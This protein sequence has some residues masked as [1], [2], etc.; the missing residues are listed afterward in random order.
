[1]DLRVGD[2]VK[3]KRSA[4]DML[5]DF[6]QEMARSHNM[7]VTIKEV[8]E[9]GSIYKIEED[10]SDSTWFESE[11]EERVGMVLDMDGYNDYQPYLLNKPLFWE[12]KALT[13]RVK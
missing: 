5:S 3:L 1:M 10:H 4:I 7:I 9:G 8:S 13:R 2:K 12:I 6:Y 11:F